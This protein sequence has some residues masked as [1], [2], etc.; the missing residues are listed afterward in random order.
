VEFCQPVG[1]ITKSALLDAD[2]DVLQALVKRANP[3]SL[4]HH[5]FS[6]RTAAQAVEPFGAFADA[7]FHAMADS[8]CAGSKVG[9]ELL[10]GDSRIDY[11]IFLSCWREQR[12]PA[13]TQAFITCF[14]CLAALA[15]YFEQRLREQVAD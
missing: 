11:L 8:G 9:M 1:I 13:P 10:S 15:P 12:K 7:R 4:L 14:V 3:F 6:D 5:R 2:I